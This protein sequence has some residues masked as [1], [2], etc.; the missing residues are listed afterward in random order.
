M[1]AR[2]DFTAALNGILAGLSKEEGRL[3]EVKSALYGH[4]FASTLAILEAAH[5]AVFR[6]YDI[7]EV[8]AAWSSAGEDI[9]RAGFVVAL[10]DGRRAY[11][12][13]FLGVESGVF[14]RVDGKVYE[15]PASITTTWL[16]E[17]Q[18]YPDLPANHY[19][20]LFGWSDAPGLEAFVARLAGC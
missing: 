3:G 8:S 20:Q 9:W 4:Y 15:E 10:H 16:K 14:E 1:I 2:H 5:D 13:A 6:W 17:R 7:A 12:D 18:Q 11:I 19:H